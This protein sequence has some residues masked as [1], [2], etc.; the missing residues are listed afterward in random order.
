MG[1]LAPVHSGWRRFTPRGGQGLPDAPRVPDQLW[2]R[3][4]YWTLEK[5]AGDVDGMVGE[6]GKL[7]AAFP[8]EPTLRA[9]RDLGASLQVGLCKLNPVDV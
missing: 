4:G 9:N 6:W 3:G 8:E 5:R 2:D 1:Q 7:L